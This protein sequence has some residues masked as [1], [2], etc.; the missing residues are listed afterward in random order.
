MRDF[1]VDIPGGG[2]EDFEWW[3]EQNK[4]G[5]FVNLTAPGK[6]MLHRGNCGHMV[7]G[8]KVN[9]VRYRKWCSSNRRELEDRARAEGIV[10]KACSDCEV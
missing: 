6:A 3:L 2:S 8:E 5:Y 10:L 9:L 7:F 4:D 1:G